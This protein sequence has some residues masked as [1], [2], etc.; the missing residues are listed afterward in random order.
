MVGFFKQLK[1]GYSAY[2]KAFKIIFKHKMIKYFIIPVILNILL[3]WGA[4]ELAGNLVDLSLETIKGWFQFNEFWQKVFDGFIGILVRLLIILV[5]I[6]LSGY[7]VIAIMSPIYAIMSEKVDYIYTKNEY[8]FSFKQLMIDIGRGIGI[9]TRN[10]LIETFVVIAVLF[11]GLIPVIGWIGPIIL[12]LVSS[13]FY[14]FSYMDYTNERK[15]R[16]LRQSVWVV[17]KYKGIAFAN[18]SVFALIMMSFCGAALAAFFG[19]VS[20]IAASIAMIEIEQEEQNLS[21]LSKKSN[22]KTQD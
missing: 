9:V 6:Y 7:I 10:V 22:E 19:G 1:I 18:G 2:G 20:T 16:N 11:I 3:F 12:F 4:W 21:Q 5:F 8:P 14:G 17:R 15:K 13:Y